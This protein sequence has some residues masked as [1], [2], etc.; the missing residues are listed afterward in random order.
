[1]TANNE[2]RTRIFSRGTLI[3]IAAALALMVAIP[4]TAYMGSHGGGNNSQ[5]YGGDSNNQNRGGYGQHQGYGH[6]YERGGLYGDSGYHSQNG[7]GN[8]DGNGH[9]GRGHGMGGHR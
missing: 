9:G 6:G 7:Y 2:T 5:Q 3:A 8:H 1:M 4:A